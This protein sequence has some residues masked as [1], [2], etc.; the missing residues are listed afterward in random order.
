MIRFAEAAVAAAPS[1]PAV[2]AG[3]AAGVGAEVR[4]VLSAATAL[5]PTAPT[6]PTNMSVHRP[7]RNVFDVIPLSNVIY[8]FES[9]AGDYWLAAHT[10]LSDRHIGDMLSRIRIF[11]NMT[12]ACHIARVNVTVISLRRP[13]NSKFL[14]ISG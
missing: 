4:D 11:F 3:A 10:I 1:P 6:A 14:R 8:T 2:P 13:D 5:A 9:F 12:L 7:R